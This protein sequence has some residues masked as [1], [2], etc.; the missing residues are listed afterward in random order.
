MATRWNPRR[1]PGVFGLAFDPTGRVLASGSK[2]QTVKLW[3]APGA[4]PQTLLGHTHWPH[5]LAFSPDGQTLA[6]GP[7]DR[8]SNV[9]GEVKL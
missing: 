9:V 8:M 2:D 4:D 5:A 3:T 7:A 1:A 6:T